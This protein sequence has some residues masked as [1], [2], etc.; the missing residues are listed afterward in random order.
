[1]DTGSEQC[2][3]MLK[4]AFVVVFFFWK[5]RSFSQNFA[6]GAPVDFGENS[7]SSV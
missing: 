5:F 3:K 1:M 7:L 4:M 2:P 6:L